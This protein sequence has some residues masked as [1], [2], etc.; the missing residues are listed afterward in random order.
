MKN[1]V[2]PIVES[3]D[4]RKSTLDGTLTFTTVLSPDAL[5]MLADMLGYYSPS[6]DEFADEAAKLLHQAIYLNYYRGGARRHQKSE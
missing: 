6:P 3:G 5:S 4:A 2:K 1:S